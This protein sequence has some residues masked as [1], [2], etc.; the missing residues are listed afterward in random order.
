[1]L[2]ATNSF[3]LLWN[4]WCCVVFAELLK[5]D[6]DVCNGEGNSNSYSLR[7]SCTSTK[8]ENT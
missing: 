5:N 8:R 4:M 3:F 1:M 2:N 7:K 6:V